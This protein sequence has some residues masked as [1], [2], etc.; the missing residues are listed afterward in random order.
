MYETVL[1]FLMCITLARCKNVSCN[2]IGTFNDDPPFDKMP[3]PECLESMEMMPMHKLYTRKNPDTHEL[4]TEKE[5]PKVFDFAKNTIIAVHGW[6]SDS[7]SKWVLKLKQVLLKKEDVNVILLDWEYGA[8]NTIYPQSASNTRSV[9]AYSAVVLGNL[10]E[11]H[12]YPKNYIWCIGHSLGSHVCGH[13][14]MKLKIR[15][16]TGLDPAGPY[17]E[18]ASNVTVGVNPSSADFVDII[19]TDNV[20]GTTKSLGHLDF[21]PN[22]GKQQPGCITNSCSHS[23]ATTFMI[24]SVENDCFNVYKNC[25]D[26]HDIPESCSNCNDGFSCGS[27]GYAA[28]NSS[29]R[30]GVLYLKTSKKS[31]YCQNSNKIFHSNSIINSILDH[32]Y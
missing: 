3:L 32:L 19:H 30:I 16:V 4:L 26:V 29:I 22:G 18:G 8:D 21:Y 24:E 14:G 12:N 6:N 25:T 28:D 17:F 7:E 1:L 2:L 31:P 15:R 5:I 11:K 20:L 13:L 9:G 10:V 23:L 27:M